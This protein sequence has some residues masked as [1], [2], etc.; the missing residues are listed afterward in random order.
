MVTGKDIK[1]FLMLKL[2][3]GSV[4]HFLN[5]YAKTIRLNFEGVEIP[6]NHLKN[7]GSVLIACWH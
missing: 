5:F 1:F 6:L 7:G 4:Y 3:T 2:L